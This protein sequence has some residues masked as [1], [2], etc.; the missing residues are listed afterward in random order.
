M[1]N[2]TCVCVVRE[3][4]SVDF[5]LVNGSFAFIRGAVLEHTQLNVGRAFHLYV[6][7]DVVRGLRTDY[8]TIRE[9]TLLESLEMRAHWCATRIRVT[10]DL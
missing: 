7:E 5:D 1:A 2:T 6:L 9:L 3:D 4:G 8:V 10:L